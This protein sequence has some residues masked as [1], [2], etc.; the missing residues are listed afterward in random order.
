VQSAC[1]LFLP[2]AVVIICLPVVYYTVPGELSVARG[3]GVTGELG[4]TGGLDVA[5]GLVLLSVVIDPLYDQAGEIRVEG[6]F[7]VRE[8]TRSV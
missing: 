6:A 3:L 7:L 2:V 8:L 1:S 4:V 5:G